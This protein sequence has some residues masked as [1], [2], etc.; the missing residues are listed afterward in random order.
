MKRV[1]SAIMTVLLL[2][3]VLSMAAT[4]YDLDENGYPV[5]VDIRAMSKVEAFIRQMFVPFGV[6]DPNPV[7][8]GQQMRADFYVTV[9][10]PS[11]CVGD[12]FTY[13][14]EHGHGEIRVG[15]V[16]YSTQ[17]ITV[18]HYIPSDTPDGNYEMIGYVHGPLDCRASSTDSVQF[19]VGSEVEC[20]EGCEPWGRCVRGIKTRTCYELVGNR[21]VGNIETDTCE[22]P[23]TT[24][25]TVPDD[26][27]CMG[28]C[29]EGYKLECHP[30]DNQ[31]C[32]KEKP[33]IDMKMLAYIV[34]IIG[35]IIIVYGVF[36][37]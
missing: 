33:D 16:C 30:V 37:G 25:T 14:W 18:T 2:S 8:P 27:T 11:G 28:P 24:T 35:G 36:N 9:E 15:D 3:P 29:E 12:H 26:C 6:A 34:M 13:D 17:M 10:C 31:C 7:Q 21:C 22:V 20:D 19:T 4:F 5:I 1:V 23:T 32:T